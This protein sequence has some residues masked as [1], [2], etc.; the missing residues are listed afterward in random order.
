MRVNTPRMFGRRD[1]MG[2]HYDP[3]YTVP[4]ARDSWSTPREFRCG[5]LMGEGNTACTRRIGHPADFHECAYSKEK[6][7][8]RWK[9]D[10]SPTDPH[11]ATELMLMKRIREL[12]EQVK[13]IQRGNGSSSSSTQRRWV[14]E[15]ETYI[16]SNEYGA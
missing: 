15:E 7:W 16:P 4:A 10:L 13:T 12:E 6:A 14:S 8:G 1:T 2:W 9:V 3:P 11:T 5:D